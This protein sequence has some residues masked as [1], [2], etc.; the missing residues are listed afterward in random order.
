MAASLRHQAYH[1]RVQ[2]FASFRAKWPVQP[3]VQ[4]DPRQRRGHSVAF[5]VEEL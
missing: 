1:E 3:V 5:R 4:P 2:A